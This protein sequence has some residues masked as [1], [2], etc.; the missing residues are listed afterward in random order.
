MERKRLENRLKEL[1]LGREEGQL[2]DRDEVAAE[3]EAVLGAVRATLQAIPDRVALLLEGIFA[4]EGG[5]LRAAKI[6]ALIAAELDLVLV[7]LYRGRDTTGGDA[8]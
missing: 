6:R 1:R 7:A 3:A 5:E 2:L 8:A 4:A